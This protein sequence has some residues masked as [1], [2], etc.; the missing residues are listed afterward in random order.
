MRNSVTLSTVLL[1]L[2]ANASAPA[3]SAPKRAFRLSDWYRVTTIRQPALSPDGRTV[4]FTVTTVREAENKRHSEVW[5]VAADGSAAPR[6]LTSQSAE[7]STPRWAP[8]GK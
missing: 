2:V 6:R 1:V 4:A 8:D 5:V 3:Q 7:S